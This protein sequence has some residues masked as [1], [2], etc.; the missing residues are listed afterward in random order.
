MNLLLFYVTT[1]QNV[2][3]QTCM[4]Y[5]VWFTFDVEEMVENENC[6]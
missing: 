4:E 1:A 5:G 2:G 6:E 3:S